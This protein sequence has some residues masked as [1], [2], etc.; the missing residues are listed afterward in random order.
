MDISKTYTGKYLTKNDFPAPRQVIIDTVTMENV[1]QDNQPQEL[2]PVIF[3]KGAPKG[4]VLNKTNATIL[5]MLY[6]N[7]T[8]SWEGQTVECFNDVTI[9]YAGQITGGLRIRPVQ[10]VAQPIQAHANTNGIPPA[11]NP[12]QPAD[13]PFND[14]IPEW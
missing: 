6:G 4:M 7:L 1:A 14:Q 2:K 3:F 13:A 10:Q 9:Q 12:G 5:Q 11:D 8:E